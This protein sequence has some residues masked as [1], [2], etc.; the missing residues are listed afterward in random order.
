M[1]EMIGMIGMPI[2]R[3]IHSDKRPRIDHCAAKQNIREVSNCLDGIYRS[4]DERRQNV[5]SGRR[6][7][8]IRIER[9]QLNNSFQTVTL[10]LY[11][12]SAGN[13]LAFDRCRQT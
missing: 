7:S 13:A 3:A 2:T 10:A 12:V 11:M 6:G 9:F 4:R 1:I 8:T 5:D